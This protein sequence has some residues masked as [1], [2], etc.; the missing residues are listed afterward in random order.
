MEGPR[1]NKSCLVPAVGFHFQLC[2][3][4]HQISFYVGQGVGFRKPGRPGVAGSVGL[5]D[6]HIV[7]MIALQRKNYGLAAETS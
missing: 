5:A 1:P 7:G 6:L 4:F 2:H 3:E